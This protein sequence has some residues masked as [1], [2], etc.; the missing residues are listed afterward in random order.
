MSCSCTTI[1]CWPSGVSIVSPAYL[2]YS[3]VSPSFTYIKDNDCISYVKDSTGMHVYFSMLRS[4]GLRPD[5]KN[6]P[7]NYLGRVQSLTIAKDDPACFM[8]VDADGA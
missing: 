6:D 3:T 1:N 2:K 8:V 7:Y 5:C 4:M